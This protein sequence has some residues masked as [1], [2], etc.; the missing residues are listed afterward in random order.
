MNRENPYLDVEQRML[1]DIYTSSAP[2][3]NLTV[4]CDDFG[5]RFA[6]TPGERQAVEFFQKCF[7]EYGLEN[8]RAEE[9]PYMGWTRG[10]AR[11]TV[12]HPVERELG[13]ISLPYS[14]A[15]TVEAEVV[16]LKDGA[17]AD[18]EAAGAKLQ[19]QIAMVCSRP[20]RGLNRTVH[21]SEKYHRSVLGG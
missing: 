3:D 18:F 2:M 1:G 8:V 21:R 9:Y 5:S 11:V 20:P 16:W 12:V 17:P 6:G 10:P 13:C 4:L 14:P 19:G 7:R 15:G